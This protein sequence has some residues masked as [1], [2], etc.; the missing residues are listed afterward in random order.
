MGRVTCQNSHRCQNGCNGWF[1]MWAIN[2]ADNVSS[3]QSLWIIAGNPARCFE[4]VRHRTASDGRDRKRT[5]TSFAAGFHC[6]EHRSPRKM[7]KQLSRAPPVAS[8]LQLILVGGLILAK[9]PAFSR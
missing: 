1:R 2:A 5:L 9:K 6:W 7:R 3:F 4:P 8:D